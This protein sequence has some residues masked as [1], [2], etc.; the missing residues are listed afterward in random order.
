M[1]VHCSVKLP[2]D[3]IISSG[4]F[5]IVL[6][7]FTTVFS[8]AFG[9]IPLENVI[10]ESRLFVFI[11]FRGRFKDCLLHNQQTGVSNL[12]TRLQSGPSRS[13]DISANVEKNHQVLQ[14]FPRKDSVKGLL[15]LPNVIAYEMT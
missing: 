11:G 8:S 2:P 14:K 4:K 15:V 6:L 10:R 13:S 1:N 5:S 3:F 12:Q 9:N 7:A